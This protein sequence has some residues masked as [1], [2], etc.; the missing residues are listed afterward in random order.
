MT[1]EAPKTPAPSMSELSLVDISVSKSELI[2]PLSDKALK[3]PRL[4]TG[5]VPRRDLLDSLFDIEPQLLVL[6]AGAGMGKTILLSQYCWEQ[7]TRSRRAV[8]WLSL[9]ATEEEPERFLGALSLS[10]RRACPEVG[11]RLQMLLLSAADIPSDL[12][13]MLLCNELSQYDKAISLVLDNCEAIQSDV[14]WRL[15]KMLL[16]NSGNS[17]Q[18]L[19]ASRQ[20]IPLVDNRNLLEG[21]QLILSTQSLRFTPSEA[22]EFM[23]HNFLWEPPESVM[24]ACYK[25][26]VGW[27]LLLMAVKQKYKL[28]VEFT[29]QIFDDLMEPYFRDYCRKYNKQDLEIILCGS[30][31]NTP[32]VDMV[33]EILSVP[34][35]EVAIILRREFPV[36]KVGEDITVLHP[37]FKRFVHAEMLTE[38]PSKLDEFHRKAAQLYGDSGEIREAVYH[39]LF[40][41]DGENILSYLEE[42]MM[43]MMLKSELETLND[44]VSQLRSLDIKLS[45]HQ[46]GVL[47]LIE[48]WTKAFLFQHAEVTERL[49]IMQS[50]LANDEIFLTDTAY[51]T[52]LTIKILNFAYNERFEEAAK[53]ALEVLDSQIEVSH[54]I[55]GILQNIMCY[56]SIL[57]LDFS[58]AEFYQQQLSDHLDDRNVFV[59]TY[60]EVLFGHYMVKCARWPEAKIY[61]CK[62]LEVSESDGNSHS[63]AVGVAVGFLSEYYYETHQFEAVEKEVWYRLDVIDAGALIDASYRAYLSLARVLAVRLEYERAHELLD[64]GIGHAKARGWDRMLAACLCEHIKYYTL[65]KRKKKATECLNQ[66][67]SID[68]RNQNSESIVRDEVRYFF[69]IAQALSNLSE[70]PSEN[71][72]KDLV[73][74]IDLLESHGAHL[75]AQRLKVALVIHY[76]QKSNRLAGNKIL[77][78]VI[79]FCLENGSPSVLLD[80]GDVIFNAVNSLVNQT[81]ELKSVGEIWRSLTPTSVNGKPEGALRNDL[82]NAEIDLPQMLSEK[83]LEVITLLSSGLSNKDI[84]GLLGISVGTVK[85]HLSNLYRKM[86]VS[87]RTEAVF[88]AKVMG[89][90]T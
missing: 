81:D 88:E 29:T 38:S 70:C 36:V 1:D 15:I 31:L 73:A 71:L 22:K 77:I 41:D 16:D 89:L 64:R 63:I 85:W 58:Q 39:C 84:S 51:V 83:E 87:S 62:G 32:S 25:H 55:K 56:Y 24:H 21:K 34:E 61:L 60:S 9:S 78:P 5:N 50:R 12:A 76:F 74:R 59:R 44:W 66:L 26:S 69:L 80:S 47:E 52:L 8:A 2:L 72:E 43:E 7:R 68:E 67:W 30:I 46:E 90:I 65:E 14:I 3:A 49:E 19:C 53:L 42:V 6:Q 57:K 37:L 45:Q 17:L 48:L 75:Y 79:E 40:T 10:L 35:D 54:W 4:E 86:S 28:P 20:H 23:L 13:M 82:S 11:E 18:L 27:P 33:S